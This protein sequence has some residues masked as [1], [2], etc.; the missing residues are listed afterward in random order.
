MLKQGSKVAS[1]EGVHVHPYTSIPP[2]DQQTDQIAIKPRFL[3][4]AREQWAIFERRTPGEFLHVRDAELE[5]AGITSDITRKQRVAGEIAIGPHDEARMRILRSEERLE[6]VFLSF[7]EVRQV[8]APIGMVVRPWSVS[9]RRRRGG[10]YW[11]DGARKVVAVET[12]AH[13]HASVDFSN[14][15]TVQSF[16]DIIDRGYLLGLET[17]SQGR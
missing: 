6:R 11:A 2:D 7:A 5:R 4:T 16:G 8:G 15:R 10:R 3:V 13:S 12:V 9:R 14:P 17:S 1:E